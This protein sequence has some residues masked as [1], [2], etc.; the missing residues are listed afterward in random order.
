MQ[1]PAPI[2][3]PVQAPDQNP[4]QASA[5]EL[6]LGPTLTS[7]L[8]QDHALVN[9]FTLSPKSA[10]ECTHY[11]ELNQGP[12]SPSSPLALSSSPAYL[13]SLKGQ[14]NSP[15]LVPEPAESAPLPALNLEPALVTDAGIENAAMGVFT[16]ALLCVWAAHMTIIVSKKLLGEG[17]FNGRL[18]TPCALGSF[19]ISTVVV[20]TP[21]APV[22]CSK[23]FYCHLST[24]HF[25]DSL[26]VHTCSYS[27]SR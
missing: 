17:S 8:C 15:S 19:D 27:K 6:S 21:C 23:A 9:V 3:S 25:P 22:S 11:T 7:E 16:L 20:C 1:A 26:M 2:Q 13:E 10:P 24:L 5:H 4:V 14:P 18:Y 12:I